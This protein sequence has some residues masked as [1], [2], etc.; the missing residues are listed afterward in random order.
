M[1]LET[2]KNTKKVNRR[3]IDVAL[4]GVLPFIKQS[5]IRRRG[6]RYVYDALIL[7]IGI[8]QALKRSAGIM[9]NMKNTQI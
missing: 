1:S 6:V 3:G 7:F 4:L 8:F 9:F 2:D 5:L